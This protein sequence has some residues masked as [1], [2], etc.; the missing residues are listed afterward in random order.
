MEIVKK[1]VE[2]IY[3]TREKPLISTRTHLNIAGKQLENVYKV[4]GRYVLMT[5]RRL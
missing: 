5:E 1:H 3:N 2:R 4:S